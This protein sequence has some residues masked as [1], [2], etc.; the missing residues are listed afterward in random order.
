MATKKRYIDVVSTKLNFA[1]ASDSNPAFADI[2]R[3]MNG[4]DY[5]Y[6]EK[7]FEF[8]LIRTKMLNCIVGI[9]VTTQDKDIPPIRNKK[10]KQ[11]SKVN[12]NPKTQGLAYANIFL[13]DVSRNILLYE[14][15]RNGCFPNQLSEFVC[16][17]WNE[18]NENI[19]FDLSFPAVLRANEYSRML[20]M[21]SYKRLTIELYNPA[22]LVNCFDEDTDSIENNI[23]KH[24]IQVGIHGNADTLKIEQVAS[25]KKINPMGLS[26]SLTRRLIDTVKLNIAGK[27][28]RS[29]I[30]TLRVEGYS[31][32]V[33]G[34]RATI[35]PIDIL[36]DTFNEHFKITDIQ[37]QSDVQQS[38]RK[39]GIELLY[40]KLLPELRQLTR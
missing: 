12:I 39:E 38:E 36:A 14:I 21:D 1:E 4:K 30:Q 7:I 19:R 15:N 23:I 27:G 8:S 11:Y 20:A 37:L 3:F 34:E 26:K 24:N 40:E 31:S 9:V 33:E 6:L 25:S 32:D 29:N 16:S 35:K 22:E 2:L 18:Q 5:R 17:K 13:Y 10:T 28:F